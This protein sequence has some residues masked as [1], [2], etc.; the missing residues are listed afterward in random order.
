MIRRLDGLTA[1][2]LTTIFATFL[3]FSC[4]AKQAPQEI[5]VKVPADY[6]GELNLD[7]CSPKFSADV[8]VDAKGTGQTSV[9]PKSGESVTLIIVK[10]VKGDPE[11]RVPPDLVTIERAGDGL[12]VAIKARIPAQ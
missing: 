10:G 6:W 9:C 3:L 5:T 11:L 7:P 12:P 1:L 8:S 2:L 4:A